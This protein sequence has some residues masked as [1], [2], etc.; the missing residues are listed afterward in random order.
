MLFIKPVEENGIADVGA[1]HREQFV[2]KCLRGL[3]GTALR[4]II[5]KIVYM[6]RR[7]RVSGQGTREDERKC[8]SP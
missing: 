8:L 3:T 7:K 2:N 1:C 5:R 4:C 6:R